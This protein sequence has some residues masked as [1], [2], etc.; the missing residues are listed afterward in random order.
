MCDCKMRPQD[1]ESGWGRPL[2]LLH[3]DRSDLCEHRKAQYT[4]GKAAFVLLHLPSLHLF[5]WQRVWQR[6]V[7]MVQVWKSEDHFCASVLTFCHVHPRHGT[8]VVRLGSQCHNPLTHLSNPTF[9][10]L[11]LEFILMFSFLFSFSFSFRF[12]KQGFL[13]IVPA[14]FEL[15]L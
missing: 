6:H 4:M 11:P 8:H 5:I 10:S 15:T 14:V 1:W 9:T 12:L 7:V 2:S 3:S 13:C